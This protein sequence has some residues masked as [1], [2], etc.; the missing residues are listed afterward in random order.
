MVSQELDFPEM[1][2]L[3]CPCCPGAMFFIVKNEN[4]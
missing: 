2:I 3:E 1:P 4:E